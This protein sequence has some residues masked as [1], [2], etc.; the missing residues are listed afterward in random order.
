V[1]LALAD[2]DR[3]TPFPPKPV[4]RLGLPG[5]AKQPALLLR[6]LGS[7]RTCGS[8]TRCLVPRSE[9]FRGQALERE[10]FL[11]IPIRVPSPA[12][13]REWTFGLLN[14]QAISCGPYLCGQERS[15]GSGQVSGSIST[16]RRQPEFA[17][18]SRTR[19]SP[20]WLNWNEIFLNHEQ[21]R[22][23]SPRICCNA[24]KPLLECS[25]RSKPHPLILR[26]RPCLT[27]STRNP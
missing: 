15:W 2:R 8:Q 21:K 1:S 7:A 9:T 16:P 25:P 4:A 13:A 19:P 11:R 14:V 23:A 22:N 5:L 20:I 26:T 18:R 10:D 6:V 3:A 17:R 27:N 12:R 24:A